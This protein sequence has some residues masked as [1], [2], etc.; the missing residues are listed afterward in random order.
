VIFGESEE[1]LWGDRC[2]DDVPLCA[3]FAVTERA[4][5]IEHRRLVFALAWRMRKPRR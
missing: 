3:A 1:S 4:S 5:A 2:D